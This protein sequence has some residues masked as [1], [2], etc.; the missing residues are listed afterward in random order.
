LRSIEDLFEMSLSKSSTEK[1]WKK[2]EKFLNNLL[3]RIEKF[4]EAQ[5][6]KVFRAN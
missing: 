4:Q 5:T 6:G 2:T 1:M 3:K